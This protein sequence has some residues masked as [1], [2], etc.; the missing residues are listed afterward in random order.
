MKLQVFDPPMCCSSGV[1]G[2]GVDPALMKFAIVLH[3]LGKT[4]VEIERFNLSSHPG[5]F[6]RQPAVREALTQNGDASLPMILA[7]GI[8]LFKGT[9]PTLDELLAHIGNQPPLHQ[10]TSEG[11]GS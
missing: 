11:T 7:D 4:G 8:V 10:P 5:E 9:Y 6:A 2:P 3:K 1:C